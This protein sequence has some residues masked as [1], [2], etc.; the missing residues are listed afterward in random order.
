MGDFSSV[1]RLVNSEANV[2]L[3]DNEG[4]TALMIACCAG[5]ARIVEHL[6]YCCHGVLTQLNLQDKNGRTAL[7]RSCE[8]EST[9]CMTIL[10]NSGAQIDT[11]DNEGKTVLM[12]VDGP[13]KQLLSKHATHVRYYEGRTTLM[14]FCAKNKYES[15]KSIAWDE[16]REDL[17]LQ[18]VDGR[19]PLMIACQAKNERIVECLCDLKADLN[20]LQ[21]NHGKTALMIACQVCNLDIVNILLRYNYMEHKWTKWL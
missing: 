4:N 15:I 18:D 20:N 1:E 7:M 6:C 2:N 12:M 10:L 17:N 21:D 5:N 14:T 9:E 8:V 3:K 16:N 19:T 13:K 11:E